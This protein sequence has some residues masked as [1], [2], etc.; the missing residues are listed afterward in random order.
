MHSLPN[1]KDTTFALFDSIRRSRKAR[2]ARHYD[3][4]RSHRGHRRSR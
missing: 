3:R 4:A 1:A 2:G